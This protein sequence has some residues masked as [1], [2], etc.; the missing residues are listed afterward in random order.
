[1]HIRPTYKM[2]THRRGCSTW[3]DRQGH[4]DFQR[5]TRQ[6]W[7]EHCTLSRASCHSPSGLTWGRPT[8][9]PAPPLGDI[10]TLLKGFF[11]S[12]QYIHII[13]YI[14]PQELSLL[15][16]SIWVLSAQKGDI[17]VFTQ[18]ILSLLLYSL[19]LL[20][21]KSSGILGQHYKDAFLVWTN[22][23]DFVSVP[24]MW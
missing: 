20:N 11:I 6:T 21:A 8:P 15:L 17:T 9:L 14:V 19:I 24:I 16:I 4:T 2:V 3:R 13:P 7:Q 18:I 23:I 10:V 22:I 12:W 1:M 5:T